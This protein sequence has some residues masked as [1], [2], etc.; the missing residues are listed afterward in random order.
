MVLLDHRLAVL[1]ERLGSVLVSVLVVVRR[2]SIDTR[3]PG[4]DARL[5]KVDV[6]IDYSGND[7]PVPERGDLKAGM[8]RGNFFV[9]AEV[10][11]QAIL[12]Y[13]PSI[14]NEAGTLGF[15]DTTCNQFPRVLDEIKECP[16]NPL[17]IRS[18]NSAE[19]G[20]Q[21]NYAKQMALIQGYVLSP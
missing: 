18:C 4:D 12:N 5:G 19:Q 1:V 11:D 15:V 16:S 2:I 17:G 10:N 13:Q 7:E 14:W 6:P 9:R 3:H 8:L 20:R 21:N